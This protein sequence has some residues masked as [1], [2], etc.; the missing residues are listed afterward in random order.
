MEEYTGHKMCK[1]CWESED[2]VDEPMELS[3]ADG[4]VLFWV[5]VVLASI[6]VAAVLVP[7]FA[8]LYKG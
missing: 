8:C 4:R 5:C 1:R 3:E 6:V 7:V 2:Y